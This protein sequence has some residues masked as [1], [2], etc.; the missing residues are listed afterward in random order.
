MQSLSKNG[1]Y[2]INFK[3]TINQ[4]LEKKVSEET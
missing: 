1:F 2:S 4:T 3:S